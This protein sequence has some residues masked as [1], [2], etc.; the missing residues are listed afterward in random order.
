V[1]ADDTFLKEAKKIYSISRVVA[2]RMERYNRRKAVPLYPPLEKPEGFS[3]AA[4]EDFFFYPGRINAI[5]RQR[6]AVEAM[7]YV[8]TNARLIIAGAAEQEKDWTALQE[9]VSRENLQQKVT[10]L[11]PIPE[12][13]KIDL[14]AR[15]IGCLN[16]PYNEDYGYVTL[17]S[18]YSRKPVIT[19]SDSAGPLEFVEN[20]GNG[21]ISPPDPK[22][23]ARAMDNF[24][25]DKTRAIELG[26]SGYEKILSLD[27]SWERVVK[28][29]VENIPA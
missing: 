22:E 13:K 6:L 7:K 26:K 21:A 29:L 16:I 17:E 23:L 24:F 10:L 25:S 4:P 1:R 8:K 20:D 14:L 3:C 9:Q 27:I 15:C 19:C 11:G 28:E 18:F 12:E 2:D 5:K